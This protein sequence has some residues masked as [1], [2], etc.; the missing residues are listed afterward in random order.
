MPDWSP[1]LPQI[2]STG[3]TL[4]LRLLNPGSPDS[5]HMEVTID[6]AFLPFTKSQVFRVSLPGEQLGATAGF[7]PSPSA[8]ILKLY[9]RRYIDDRKG[10][11]WSKELEACARRSWREKR[12]DDI[13]DMDSFYRYGCDFE[14]DDDAEIEDY[15]RWLVQVR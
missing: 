15:F 9:D 4:T 10:K 3:N 11:E 8:A 12:F 7:A 2:Y 14:E 5:D 1:P 13:E 6:Y